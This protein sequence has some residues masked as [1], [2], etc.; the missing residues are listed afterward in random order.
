ME[1]LERVYNTPRWRLLF[2]ESSSQRT[3][4]HNEVGILLQLRVVGNIG[5][6]LI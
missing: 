5:S 6:L 3:P 4:S 2:L 1:D